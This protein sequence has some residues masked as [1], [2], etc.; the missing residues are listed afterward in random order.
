M[1]SPISTVTVILPG[2]KRRPDGTLEPAPLERTMSRE[3]ALRRLAGRQQRRVLASMPNAAVLTVLDPDTMSCF[4]SPAE[5]RHL[6][7]DAE[8][9]HRQQG[10]SRG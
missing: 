7:D 6:A 4:L 5:M 1:A 8:E 9:Y 3:E 10:G 2:L